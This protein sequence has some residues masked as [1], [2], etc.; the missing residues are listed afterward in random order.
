[1]LLLVDDNTADLLVFNGLVTFTAATAAAFAIELGDA[2]S[3]SRPSID[4]VVGYYTLSVA[5][6]H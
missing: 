5:I 2:A 3:A 6:I 4:G 1:M